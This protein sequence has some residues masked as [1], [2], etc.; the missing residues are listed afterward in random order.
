MATI[1]KRGETYRVKIRRKGYDPVTASFDTKAQAEEFA[2]KVEHQMDERK[3]KRV[4]RGTVG[5]L[6]ED[7]AEKVSPTKK[8]ERWE[9]IRLKRLAAE[10]GDI[11]LAEV[12]QGAAWLRKWRDKRL[13]KVK[14]SSVNRELGLISAVFTY[15]IKENELNIPNPVSMIQRPQNSKAR[16]VRMHADFVTGMLQKM[17]FDETKQPVLKKDYVPWVFLLALETAMRLGELLRLQ[18]ENVYLDESWCRVYDTKNGD[19]YRDIPLTP[20]AVELMGKLSQSHA[21][22]F[23]ISAGTFDVYWREVRP[24]GYRFHDSRHEATTRLAGGLTNILE[25]A[26]VTGHHDLRYL[27]VYFNPTPQELAAKISGV[28]PASSALPRAAPTTPAPSTP[29]TEPALNP[30]GASVEGAGGVQPT[31]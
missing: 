7:Y 22:V 9:T 19:E 24:K 21:N 8:G 30:A 31:G 2:R 27:K 3:Y 18:W 29:T 28:S 16:N 25:L 26:A 1:E 10:L 17:K 23:P 11:T 4:V 14:G 15:A 13:K 12:Q 5:E 6:F 20:R